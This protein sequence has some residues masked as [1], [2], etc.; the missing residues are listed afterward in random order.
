[1]NEEL[2]HKYLNNEITETELNQ[3]KAS[4]EYR[5]YIKIAEHSSKM[6]APAFNK[7]QVW[8]SISEKTQKKTKLVPLFNFKSILKYAAVLVLIVT[9]FLY[10]NNLDSTVNTGIAE[11]KSFTLPDSSEVVLN[12]DSEINFNKKS[13][14]KSRTLSLE[15]EAFFKVA[16]GEQFDVKTAQGFVSVL[17]TQ[18]NVQSREAHFH[19]ICYEGSVRVSFNNK[20]IQLSAGNSVIIE[21]GKLVSQ[22]K[23]SVSQPG[24]MADES[25]FKNTKVALVFDELKRQYNIDLQ[26][27]NVDVNER[28]TGAFTHTNL[29]AAL[30]TICLPLQL[31]FN[32]LENGTVK[33]YGQ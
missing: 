12:A 15:G 19:V 8:Q 29:E 33:I 24:W 27:E 22:P 10:Y 11:K 26:L 3:L 25:N 6:K 23:I 1:M 4:D 13:W 14:N 20:N 5:N 18:F 16:K 30:Q 28:F 21:E 32:I 31:T 2:L 17:G 7:S 9:A